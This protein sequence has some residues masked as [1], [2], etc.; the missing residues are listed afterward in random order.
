MV[1]DLNAGQGLFMKRHEPR[2]VMELVHQT[3]AEWTNV[4]R[5]LAQ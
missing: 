5:V 3:G 4:F 2:V 1:K